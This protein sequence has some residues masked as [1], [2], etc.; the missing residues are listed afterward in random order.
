MAY[1][2]L[3]SPPASSDAV[4]SSMKGNKGK[5]TKPEILLRSAL[6][7]SGKRYRKHYNKLPGSPDIA[8]VSKRLAVF[9]DGCFWHGCPKCYK[10]PK[11]NTDFWRKKV[12]KNRDRA[13]I[14][15][16]DLN[17]DGWRV[18]RVWEHEIL[19][20]PKKVAKKTINILNSRDGR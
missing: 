5:D 7:R 4:K 20:G 18:L 8:F 19:E 6:H 11:T 3:R 1:K 15:N 13:K 10:E 14:V 9:V 17:R 16:K 12:Q 2:D